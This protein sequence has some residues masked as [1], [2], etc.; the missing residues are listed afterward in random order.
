M[1][2]INNLSYK[3][4]DKRILDDINLEFKPGEMVF[5]VGSSG[6]GKTSL[7]N[8]LG[9]L[10]KGKGKI[11]YEG[12]E[13]TD[14]LVSYRANEVAFVFQNYNLIS[15]MS[16]ADNMK[17]GALYSGEA[18]DKRSVEKQIS[19]FGLKDS[20]QN[21]EN[22]SGGEK[23]RVAIL[24]G[25][26]RKNRVILADEP[27]GNLDPENSELVLKELSSHKEGRYVIIVTHN[28]DLAMKY[29]DRVIR[30]QDGQVI[31]DEYV[32]E[33]KVVES[34]LGSVVKRNS[35]VGHIK[36]DALVIGTYLKKHILG[37]ILISCVIA[38]S[39][40]VMCSAVSMEKYNDINTEKL[41][42]NYMETDL[43]NV[44]VKDSFYYS[45]VFAFSGIDDQTIEKVGKLDIK[46]IVP[47]YSG[48]NQID[49]VYDKQAVLPVLRQIEANEFFENRIMQ[50]G[51]E[52]R[53]IENDDEIILASDIAE[54]LYGGDC[55]G[56]EII[57]SE[58]DGFFTRTYTIVGINKIKNVNDT[59]NTYIT[60]ESLKEFEN[61]VK[62][63]LNK[64]VLLR[65]DDRGNR[66]EG[67]YAGGMRG[68]I[69][70]GEITKL[71]Q[72]SDSVE[73]IHGRFPENK[74]E[75]CVNYDAIRYV[76][77]GVN[78]T[79]DENEMMQ[80]YEKNKE[81]TFL[82]M[83]NGFCEF[84]VVGIVKVNGDDS[85][86]EGEDFHPRVILNPVDYEEF[87]VKQRPQQLQVYVKD[88]SKLYD[89]IDEIKK[90]DGLDAYF[91]NE[92]AKFRILHQNESAKDIIRMLGLMLFG[93][94]AVIFAGF[95]IIRIMGRKH[96]V[97]IIRS[98]G[99]NFFDSAFII[100]FDALVIIALTASLGRFF[101]GLV[102]KHL[103]EFLKGYE[104]VQ[105]IYNAGV[106][107]TYIGVMSIVIFV[108]IL[109][110]SLVMSLKSC[111]T[112][113]KE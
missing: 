108:I 67:A 45:G 38:F 68:V 86:V 51:I 36:A 66:K 76:N 33:D 92:E 52:G 77:G 74:G 7:L 93:I 28:M 11:I 111:I 83:I 65:E 5:I 70:G 105:L 35:F 18:M 48:S 56:K 80:W 40:A 46:K 30:M 100:L 26:C 2:E 9:G 89:V 14:D 82:S 102:L 88:A 25:L 94:S 64:H 69:A 58:S 87:W 13:I 39:V 61:T 63:E 22:L 90:I 21:C 73:L 34:K 103:P 3:V 1:I 10:N 53:F 54:K 97:G 113:L 59:I 15:G 60:A 31:S 78:A 16:V 112:L 23:Q 72:V 49:L 44:I 62:H 50:G 75:V 85:V 42:I 110:C 4:G 8:M 24:R 55:I 47:L 6:A 84:K 101:T 79:V 57:L 104:N 17:L 81:K 32:S 99:A 107:R 37:L 43:L 20:K 95:E 29:A 41:D 71:S 19:D 106:F 98:M 27:T 12:N 96:D 109:I 91:S